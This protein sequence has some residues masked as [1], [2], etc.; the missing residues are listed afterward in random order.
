MALIVEAALRLDG[1]MWTGT[2][3]RA[4]LLVNGWA[5]FH[6]NASVVADEAEG[7]CLLSREQYRG[8]EFDGDARHGGCSVS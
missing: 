4:A 1:A 6:V 2:D 3:G 8:R 5:G 7:W